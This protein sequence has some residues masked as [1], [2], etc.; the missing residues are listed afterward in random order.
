MITTTSSGIIKTTGYLCK[1]EFILQCLVVKGSDFYC[2][3]NLKVSRQKRY[4]VFI[5]TVMQLVLD[6][7]P[8]PTPNFLWRAQA[9]IPT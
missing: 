1:V 9:K 7:C 8:A 6:I 5:S 3:Q 4:K 2:T